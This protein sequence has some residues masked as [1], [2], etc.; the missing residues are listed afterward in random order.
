MIG[1]GGKKNATRTGGPLKGSRTP[2]WSSSRIQQESL[3]KQIILSTALGL[4]ALGF[5]STAR[6]HHGNT[7]RTYVTTNS[8]VRTTVYPTRS[9]YSGRPG[10]IRSSSRTWYSRRSWLSRYGCYGY[11][12]PTYSCWYYWCPSQ[13]C[14]YPFSYFSQ[15]PPTPGVVQGGGVPP[16]GPGTPPPVPAVP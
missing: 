15:Y 2:R 14:Y 11:Y 16:M 13:S 6:A 10:P 1:A 8:V 9:I 3:M 4:A 12:N 7:G 5:T